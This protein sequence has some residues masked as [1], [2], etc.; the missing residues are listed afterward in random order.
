MDESPLAECQHVTARVD[1]TCRL[2]V[3]VMAGMVFG[4]MGCSSVPVLPVNYA[5]ARTL[6]GQYLPPEREYWIAFRQPSQ[7]NSEGLYLLQPYERGR[8]PLILVHGLASDAFTWDDIIFALKSDPVIAQK[9]QIWVYQY[10]TGVSYLRS[11]ADLRR[12]LIQTRATLDPDRSDVA[13]DETVLVGHSMGG[14]LAR[15]QISHSDDR[16]WNAVSNL[17][18]QETLQTQQVPEDIVRTF[19][20]DPVPFVR[21]VVYIAT[22]HRG[23]NWTI[24]PLGQFSRWLIELPQQVRDEWRVLVRRDG[25]FNSPADPP[26]SLDHLTPGNPIIRSL[27]CLREMPN[28]TTHSI[29]GTG[30]LVPDGYIGDG[31]VPL[32]SARR[33]GVKSEYFVR[34]T[35]SGILKA[36]PA[37]TELVRILRQ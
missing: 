11:A 4:L 20:F 22:P 30:Y 19:V 15:L 32:V 14:L 25:R 21:H 17:P 7:F 3:C 23:S 10:P 34:A 27:N 6:D 26:T 8:I 29:I 37:M 13:F 33:P 36:P 1:S 16:L 18:M 35:H 31:V 2:A 5:Q 12:D 28:A 24:Q 9:Y